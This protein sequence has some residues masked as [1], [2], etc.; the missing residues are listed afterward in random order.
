MYQGG[1]YGSFL[2]F[3]LTN[4]NTSEVNNPLCNK[5]GN[6]HNFEYNTLYNINNKYKV[7]QK[8]DNKWLKF[9][10]KMYK[11]QSLEKEINRITDITGKGILIYPSKNHY[12][13]CI[14]NQY[15]KI[16]STA[17][18]STRQDDTPKK[19]FN[20]DRDAVTFFK[21]LYNGWNIDSSIEFND[22]DRWIMRE[23]LSFYMF[24]AF[25]DE[26]EWN[27]LD[28]YTNKN[29]LVITT[30]ELLYDFENCIKKCASYSGIETI[31]NL[32]KL[33]E[34]QKQQL[35][36]QKHTDKD[37]IVNEIIDCF[38]NNKQLK[39]P[40]LSLIDE[41]YIQY[42]LRNNGYELHCDGLNEF[43]TDIDSLK[44]KTSKT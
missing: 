43:P 37:R 26:Y 23:F 13:L 35:E 3:C 16:Y 5:T 7:K 27:L 14:N 15:D 11:E 30:Y 9:H 24:M 6:S 40:E 20:D 21:N 25:D 1:S 34:L 18:T 32:D 10:P 44:E 17:I 8:C 42:V 41:A 28:T 31:N 38:L 4:L 22:I 36:L 12:L 19:W 39:I 2:I 29:L 33:I